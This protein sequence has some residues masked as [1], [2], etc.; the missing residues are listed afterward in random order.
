M[1]FELNV[2]SVV[3]L[4]IFHVPELRGAGGRGCTIPVLWAKFVSESSPVVQKNGHGITSNSSV[5]QR[6][7]FCYLAVYY[8]FIDI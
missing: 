8:I 2:W 1:G 6:I 4:I 5:F 7:S 3:R